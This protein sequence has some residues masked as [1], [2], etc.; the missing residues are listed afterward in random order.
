[1]L[2][3]CVCVFFVWKKRLHRFINPPNQSTSHPASQPG[4]ANEQE[5]VSRNIHRGKVEKKS[6]AFRVPSLRRDPYADRQAHE[7]KVK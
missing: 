6:C 3:V 7:P 1:M 4:A 5:I 2:C